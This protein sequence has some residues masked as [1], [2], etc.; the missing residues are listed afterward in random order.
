MKLLA[1]SI[2]NVN[3]LN[4][5]DLKGYLITKILMHFEDFGLGNRL[6]NVES[7]TISCSLFAYDGSKGTKNP[8]NS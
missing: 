1:L 8:K 2:R 4:I 7:L 6:R 5:E 3:Q